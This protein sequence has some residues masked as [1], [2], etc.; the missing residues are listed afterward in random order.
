M[1]PRLTPIEK[2]TGLFM[3][4]AYALSRRMLGKVM[5]PMKVLYARVPAVAGVS[6]HAS[7]V[8]DRKLSLPH[9]LRLLVTAQT[10]ALNGCGF[11]L[12][13]KHAMAVQEKLGLEKF[14]ALASYQTSPLFSDR[15]RAALDYCGEATRSRR[16]SDATFERLRKHFS[17]VEIAELTFANALENFYNLIGVPLGMESDGL[18]AIAQRRA[19]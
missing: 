1:Q 9:E 6:F 10:S 13:L 8:M 5:T 16:V 15:E 3:R 17:E 11:C 19:A 4:I 18:C 12:D 7:Y 2:P 14:Q